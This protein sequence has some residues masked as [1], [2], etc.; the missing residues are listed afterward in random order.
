MIVFLDGALIF[1]SLVS[2]Q[3]LQIVKALVA[4]EKQEAAKKAA[5]NTKTALFDNEFTVSLVFGTKKIP[6]RGSNKPIPMYANC[7]SSVVLC[8]FASQR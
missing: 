8:I 2:G 5:A 4:Y 6:E 1:D 7:S 3:T